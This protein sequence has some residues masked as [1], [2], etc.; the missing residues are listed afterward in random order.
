MTAAMAPSAELDRLVD[1]VVA[2]MRGWIGETWPVHADR[3]SNDEVAVVVDGF[4]PGGVDGFVR[5]GGYAGRLGDD[6]GAG[7][8]GPWNCVCSAVAR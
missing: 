4:F 5:S 3:M 6:H 1:V 2:D 8:D 7:C